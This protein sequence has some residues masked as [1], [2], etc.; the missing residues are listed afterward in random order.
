MYIRETPL[1]PESDCIFLHVFL[2]LF[3][4]GL[5]GQICPVL[6][7]VH[8]DTSSWGRARSYHRSSARPSSRSCILADE[9]ASHAAASR[10]TYELRGA[11]IAIANIAINRSGC[12]RL[13][14][15]ACTR[16]LAQQQQRREQQRREQ[17]RRE[18]QRFRERRG[19]AR[20]RSVYPTD[21]S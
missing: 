6:R 20:W 9:A 4:L 17:Q 5:S 13:R 16:A 10:A 2:P 14:R 21:A 18:Q 15:S 8:T 7:C 11:R 19:E 12:G 3:P 1:E